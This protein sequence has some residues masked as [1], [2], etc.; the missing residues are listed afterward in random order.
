M[1][2]TNTVGHNNIFM[3]SSKAEIPI[4]GHQTI[5]LTTTTARRSY[6]TLPGT[7][8]NQQPQNQQVQQVQQSEVPGKKQSKIAELFQKSK[9]LVVFY[10]NGLKELWANKKAAKALIQQ[11]EQQGY[12]LTRSDYQLV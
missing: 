9:A 5:V 4:I 3:N 11:V 6:A 7:T 1:G 8:D 10:K 12:Q 2:L